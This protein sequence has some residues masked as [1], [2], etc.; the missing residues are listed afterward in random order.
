MKVT[1]DPENTSHFSTGVHLV[2]GFLVFRYLYKVKRKMDYWLTKFKVYKRGNLVKKNVRF[3]LWY[4]NLGVIVTKCLA[5]MGISLHLRG[6]RLVLQ[7]HNYV[8]TITT[9][10]SYSTTVCRA[11]STNSLLISL[12]KLQY[13]MY[14][15]SCIVHTK[16]CWLFYC[17]Q[18]IYVHKFSMIYIWSIGKL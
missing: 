15:S 14:E 8:V 1:Y 16:H 11:E 13:S 12:G 10:H 17:E 4:L 3:S 7:L 6:S 18:T 9:Y 2:N 5:S